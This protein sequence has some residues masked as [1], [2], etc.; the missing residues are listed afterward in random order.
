MDYTCV[1]FSVMESNSL[2]FIFVFRALTLLV[3]RREAS[4]L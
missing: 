3:R 4:A 2:R 1:V